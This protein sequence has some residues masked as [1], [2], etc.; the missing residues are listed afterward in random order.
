MH[1]P[2]IERV[3]REAQEAGKFDDVAGS[4]EPISGLD[5]PYDPAW[6]ARRWIASERRREETLDLVRDIDRRLPQI[7]AGAVELEVRADLESLNTRIE[8]HNAHSSRGNDIPLLD[9]VTLTRERERR[10][11]GQAAQLS[12]GPGGRAGL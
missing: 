7:L 10:F 11:G 12:G 9:V 2:W 1:E 3:I 4:G 5:S 8:Q 6:W